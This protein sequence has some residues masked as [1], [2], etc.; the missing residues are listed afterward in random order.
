[1]M[2]IWEWI[3]GLVGLG[4]KVSTEEHA[5]AQED[6][7]AVKEEIKELESISVAPIDKP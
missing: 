2:E 6:R 1:M 3:K 4:K 5:G 7:T